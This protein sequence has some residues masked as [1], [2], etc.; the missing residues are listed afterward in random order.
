MPINSALPPTP[1]NG[2]LGAAP[3]PTPAARPDSL[4]KDAFLKL[5]VAQ[6]RYQDP[7][8]PTDS[9]TFM[10]QTA[11]FTQV[12]K[13]DEIAKSNQ[14]MLAAQS[15]SATGSLVGR[16]VTYI[17]DDGSDV[18]G[19]ITSASFGPNGPMLQVGTSG[20]QIPVTAITQIRQS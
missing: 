12:E 18:S 3:T 11:A 16:T 9:S 2:V 5:L 8:K 7:T 6:L 13:L 17:G 10:S 1:I 14:A 15:M 4:G 19:V 20:K